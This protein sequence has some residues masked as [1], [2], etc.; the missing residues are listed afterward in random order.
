MQAAIINI[1][2][3]IIHRNVKYMNNNILKSF[4]CTI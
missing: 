2:Y 1:Y 3:N 4:M